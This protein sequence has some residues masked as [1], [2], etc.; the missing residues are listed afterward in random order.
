MMAPKPLWTCIH[1]PWTSSIWGLQYKKFLYFKI[2]SLEVE[3]N[4]QCLAG[5]NLYWNTEKILQKANLF[6]ST[7]EETELSHDNF[8]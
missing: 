5:E 4:L 3:K 6:L 7:M 8:F 1:R 2:E